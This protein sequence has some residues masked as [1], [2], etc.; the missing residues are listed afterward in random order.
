MQGGSFL[1]KDRLHK[2]SYTPRIDAL[3]LTI[4]LLDMRAG[5]ESALARVAAFFRAPHPHQAPKK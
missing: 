3:W 4:E 5:T 1:P 2:T